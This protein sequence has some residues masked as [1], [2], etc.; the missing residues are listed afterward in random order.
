[1]PFV[2][3]GG[4]QNSDTFVRTTRYAVEL[5]AAGDEVSQE[6]WSEDSPVFCCLCRTEAAWVEQDN[7]LTQKE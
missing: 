7:P 2:C 3:T 6:D 4:C 5:N 1:M